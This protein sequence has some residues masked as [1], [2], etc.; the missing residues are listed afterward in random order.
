MKL[1]FSRYHCPMFV[2]VQLEDISEVEGRELA[3][4]QARLQHLRNLG[5]APK[6]GQVEWNRRRIDTLLVDHM[7]RSGHNRAAKAL[8]AEAGI[9]VLI[10]WLGPPCCAGW[11]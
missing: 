1:H 5:P 3:S 7:L 6:E 9:Q 10:W 11:R 4:C 2:L 8:A